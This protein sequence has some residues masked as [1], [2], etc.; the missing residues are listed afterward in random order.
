MHII[1]ATTACNAGRSQRL[2]WLKLLDAFGCCFPDSPLHTARCSDLPRIWLLSPTN[3]AFGFGHS[4]YKWLQKTLFGFRTVCGFDGCY[5]FLWRDLR[6]SLHEWVLQRWDCIED[7]RTRQLLCSVY[8]LL[9]CR[10]SLL[11]SVT[12]LQLNQKRMH[13]YDEYESG[14][15]FQGIAIL[16]NDQSCIES[17]L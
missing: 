12:M 10:V 16:I 3:L 11:Q 6:S 9:F 13:N 4:D 7:R 17:C 1:Y 5:K 8:Y 15:H 2:D 14:C